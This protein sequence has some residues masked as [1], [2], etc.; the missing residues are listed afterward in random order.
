LHTNLKG[1]PIMAQETLKSLIAVILT[2][3]LQEQEQVL[4]EVQQ[5]VD[6]LN[7]SNSPYTVEEARERLAIAKEQFANGQYKSHEEVMQQRH[8]A[9]V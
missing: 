4:A 1:T 5:N 7:S 2:L 6:E 8:R 3:S 9:A